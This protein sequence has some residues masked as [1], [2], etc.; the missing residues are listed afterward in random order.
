MAKHHLLNLR[1]LADAAV[2]DYALVSFEGREAISECFDYRLELITSAEADLK[3]WIGQLCEFDVTLE[4]GSE[5][6]FAGRIYAARRVLSGDMT[7]IL[8]RLGPAY[9]ALSYSRATHF[10]QDR[11]SLQ[12]FEAMCGDVTGLVK[13]TNFNPPVR[14]YSVRYDESELDFLARLLAQDGVMYFF[15]YDSAAGAFRHRM[16]VTTSP[17]DYVQ[18]AASPVEFRQA[19]HS[20]VVTVLER[21]H[22]AAPRKHSHVSLNVNKLD[23]PFAKSTS[24]S[25][26]WGAV[27]AHPQE[28]IGFEA[29]SAGDLDSRQMANDQWETQYAD[30]IEGRSIEPSF[31]AGGRVAITGTPSTIPKEIVLTS[32]QHSAYDTWMMPGAAPGEYHNTFTAIDAR[33]SFR[34]QVGT[35]HRVAPGP[36]LGVIADGSSAAG[37]VVVDEQWRVP[38]EIANARDYSSHGLNKYVW[39]PVKQQWQ[40]TSYGA[41]FM[42]RIGTRVI[43]D[44]LYGNPDL[45]II[46]GT[47]FNPS[48]PYPFDGKWTQS[49]WRSQTDGNGAI[50]Q[51]FHFEDQPGGEEIYLYTGRDYRREIDNDDWGTIKGNQTL[52]VEKNRELTVDENHTVTVKGKET[53]EVKQTRTI[54]V[55]QK[56][57]LE[58]LEEIEFK[59]GSSTITMKKKEIEIK[60]DNIKITAAKMLDMKADTA[61]TFKAPLID[62]VADGKLTL[63]GGVVLIN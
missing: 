15:L 21:H 54:T 43:I 52:R 31:L 33:H 24:S 44:F 6:V 28:T 30:Q 27:Y 11:S 23:T 61:A 47:I 45:P 56:N 9:H 59:V 16:I 32:V 34:P 55:T 50:V 48:Q 3:T 1:I 10:V 41:Q 18:V 37:K 40:Q 39:L 38:V 53:K 13:T 4:D 58:S 2:D 42:P 5:R 49:G 62:T 7:R 29:V 25:D 22:K 20:A 36:L 60:A 12:I 63:K 8:V 19:S 35:P 17:G 14:G 26:G 46:S 51:E 57:M